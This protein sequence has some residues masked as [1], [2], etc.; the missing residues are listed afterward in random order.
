VETPPVVTPPVETPPVE[1]PQTPEAP[2]ESPNAP[3]KEKGG[4]GVN[5]LPQEQ[6]SGGQ[7]APNTGI[8]ETNA[9]ASP[10]DTLPFTGSNIPLLVL[11]GGGFLGL[12]VGLRR[13][14]AERV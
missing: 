1:T 9:E 2:Q 5:V 7:E 6:G 8:T 4:G 3:V 12:G 11:L 14:S 13:L 10:A